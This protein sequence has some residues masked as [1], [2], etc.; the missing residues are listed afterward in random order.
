MANGEVATGCKEVDTSCN[1][2]Y[3]SGSDTR[4]KCTSSTGYNSYVLWDCPSIF[5]P[6]CM[7]YPSYHSYDGYGR[8]YFCSEC[9][10][11]KNC[12]LW[13]VPTCFS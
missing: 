4:H 9:C 6:R 11:N 8:L 10:I 12:G 3:C 7:Q 13:G 1:Q 5:N 2:G